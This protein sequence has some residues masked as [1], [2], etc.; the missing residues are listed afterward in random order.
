[1]PSHVIGTW[2]PVEK[3]AFV[4]VIIISFIS[5]LFI[6][7]FDNK[8]LKIIHI[9]KLGKENFFSNKII[10][11]LKINIEIYTIGGPKMLLFEYFLLKIV[12]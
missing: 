8:Y 10:K 7:I 1:V 9:I 5:Y 11:T 6:A 12:G 4:Y 3:P 2:P